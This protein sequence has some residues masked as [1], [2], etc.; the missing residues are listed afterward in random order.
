MKEVNRLKIILAEKNKTG[1][2]AGGAVGQRPFDCIEVVF[3][4]VAAAAGYGDSYCRTAGC[5]Y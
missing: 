4:L 1:Q 2:M 5:G 3:Q